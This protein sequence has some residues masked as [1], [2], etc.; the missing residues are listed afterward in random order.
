MGRLKDSDVGSG[1]PPRLSNRTTFMVVSLI[2]KVLSG[3]GL[4]DGSAK[5]MS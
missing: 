2:W 4:V 3:S 5:K 1:K